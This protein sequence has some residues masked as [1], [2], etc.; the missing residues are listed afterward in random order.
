MYKLLLALVF[1][2]FGLSVNAQLTL[3]IEFPSPPEGLTVCLDSSALTVRLTILNN[4][5]DNLSIQVN[6]PDGVEYIPGSLETLPATNNGATVQEADISMLQNPVFNLDVTD[7]DLSDIIEFRLERAAFCP[8]IPFSDMG[9][10]FQD[11]VV[12]AHDVQ[13]DTEISS[14]YATLFGSI[15][16]VYDPGV[17]DLVVDNV[18]TYCR[19]FELRQGGLGSIPNS[20]NHTVTVD[21]A[22]ENHEL[23]VGGVLVVP[24]SVTLVGGNNVFDYTFTFNEEPF[25]TAIGETFDNGEILRVEECFD[26]L[27]CVQDDNVMTH[28]AR[29]GC[30]GE[31]CQTSTPISGSV[32]VDYDI[33]DLVIALVQD[34]LPACYDGAAIG[35]TI[36]RVVNT[37]A[38]AVPAVF[39][40][41]LDNA[42]GGARA[43]FRSTGN[44]LQIGA[45]GVV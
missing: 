27:Q 30:E 42:G 36:F 26:I 18:G 10:I 40:Y 2:L 44:T 5:V 1:S 9:G 13:T 43:S 11:T 32:A 19:F 37:G 6:M 7:L 31:L 14:T 34:S 3:D 22:V 17:A 21:T 12:V 23:Y 15:I 8:A 16:N 45:N 38:E 29:W 41:F 28:Q 33:P 35:E 24:N 39:T 25:L 4:D 20:L